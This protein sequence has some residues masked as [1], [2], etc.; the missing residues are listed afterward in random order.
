MSAALQ[1]AEPEGPHRA[2]KVLQL[3]CL[4]SWCSKF[5]CKDVK[6]GLAPVYSLRH[7]SPSWS[8]SILRTNPEAK[9]FS[10]TLT[11]PRT[12]LHSCFCKGKG[13]ASPQNSKWSKNLV[14]LGPR[15]TL[16]RDKS[17]FIFYPGVVSPPEERWTDL[18]LL[19][20]STTP[21]NKSNFSTKKFNRFACEAAVA[22]TGISSLCGSLV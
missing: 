17:A 18:L 20:D 15:H 19:I 7:L 14:S 8:H 3:E 13:D 10:R 2:Q 22:N 16:L 4:H 21:E 1:D 12:A 9:N 11:W 5:N 6:R